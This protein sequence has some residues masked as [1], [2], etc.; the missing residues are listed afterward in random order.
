MNYW[1]LLNKAHVCLLGQVLLTHFT[2]HYAG[3]PYVNESS[4]LKVNYVVQ[5]STVA[6]ELLMAF[7]MTSFLPEVLKHS[8]NA[9]NLQIVS[10]VHIIM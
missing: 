1:L 2:A 5:W 6:H 8:T 7:S 9:N 10:V 4:Q 3:P